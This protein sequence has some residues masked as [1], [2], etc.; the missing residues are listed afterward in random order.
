MDSKKPN[1]VYNQV[2]VVLHPLFASWVPRSSRALPVYCRGFRVLQQV[3]G[4]T[5]RRKTG[6]SEASSELVT[7]RGSCEASDEKSGGRMYRTHICVL[8]ASIAVLT[9]CG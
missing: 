7:N 1:D 5:R 2:V 4:V 6:G 9:V 8:D 3:Q